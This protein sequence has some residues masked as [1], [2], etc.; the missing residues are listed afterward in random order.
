MAP[1]RK[2][3]PKNTF[4]SYKGVRQR[5]WGKWVAEIRAPEGK[6]DRGKVDRLWLGTFDTAE[7]AAR[8]Y[9]EKAIELYGEKAQLNFIHPQPVAVLG[10]TWVRQRQFSNRS[11]LPKLDQSLDTS[12]E[13]RKLPRE[14]RLLPSWDVLWEKR[15]SENDPLEN[16][17]LEDVSPQQM[18]PAEAEKELPELLSETESLPPW[19]ETSFLSL[20]GG[21]PL[22]PPDDGS[23]ELLGTENPREDW[24]EQFVYESHSYASVRGKRE[25]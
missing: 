3:G 17:P 10:N 23:W 21:N 16:T 19:E 7:E 20:C 1:R 14:L 13:E 4:Y 8:R 5:S 2:G 24:F 15:V 12:T 9:N 11:I 18:I 25:A 22:S 6:K